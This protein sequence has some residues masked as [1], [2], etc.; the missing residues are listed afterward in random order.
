MT[1]SVTPP[2]TPNFLKT[3][4]FTGNAPE[5]D[6]LLNERDLIAAQALS[7][8]DTDQITDE[9]AT[10]IRPHEN[11]SPTALESFKTDMLLTELSYR[12]QKIAMILI[13]SQNMIAMTE[14]LFS[15]GNLFPTN[16]QDLDGYNMISG[17]SDG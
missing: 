6:S 3:G 14:L 8:C 5:G 10:R 11:P 9:I 4:N 13:E 7:L 1:I 12:A 15:G 16:S 2:L 17:S